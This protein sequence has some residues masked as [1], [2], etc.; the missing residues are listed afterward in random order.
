MVI[1]FNIILCAQFWT[2]LSA[3]GTCLAAIVAIFYTCFTY[4]LLSTSNKTLTTNNKLVEFQI[5]NEIS[6]SLNTPE[7]H[8]YIVRCVNGTLNSLNEE[9]AKFIKY[10]IL[11][12]LED[13]A[14]FNEDGLISIDSIN[15]GFGSMILH[16]GN[17]KSIVDLIIMDRKIFPSVLTGFENLYNAIFQKCTE[18]ERVGFKSTLF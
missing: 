4:N 7:V 6:K 2:A 3:I 17:C 11:N 9:E 18:Q 5:Y 13:L 8:G 15:S 10:N 16:F 14:K 1:F 12:K